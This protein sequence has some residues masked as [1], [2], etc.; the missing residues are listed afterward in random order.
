MFLGNENIRTE[1]AILSIMLSMS[2]VMMSSD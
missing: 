2:N 1:M